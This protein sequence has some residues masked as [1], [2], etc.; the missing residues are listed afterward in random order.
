MLPALRVVLGRMR[1]SVVVCV[2]NVS[3]YM[4]LLLLSA[5]SLQVEGLV[6]Q[7]NLASLVTK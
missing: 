2:L 4:D 7:L 5:R 1:A 6:L 3:Q